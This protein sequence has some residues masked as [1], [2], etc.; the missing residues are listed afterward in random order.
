MTEWREWEHPRDNKGKFIRKGVHVNLSGGIIARVLGF[1]PDGRGGAWV[2]VRTPSGRTANVPSDRMTVAQPPAGQIYV[3]DGAL[4]SRFST[5]SDAS[6]PSRVGQVVEIAGDDSVSVRWGDGMIEHN[7]DP[8]SLTSDTARATTV[9]PNIRAPR[10]FDVPLAGDGL[11]VVTGEH[12]TVG[13]HNGVVTDVRPAVDA[14]G[15]DLVVY[16]DE[17]ERA[18]VTTADRVQHVMSTVQGT[19]D[20]TVKPTQ[21]IINPPEIETKTPLRSGMRYITDDDRTWLRDQGIVIPPAWQDVQVAE[22]RDASLL[23]VGR[24]AKG[25]AQYVYSAQY[26][27]NQA[28][29]KFARVRALASSLNELDSRLSDDARSDDS[30]AALML[31]RRMG[32]RPGSD[33]DTGA[34]KEARGATNLK[35]GDVHVDG[36]A[37]ALRFTGKKG[38]NI[39]L[40]VN[41]PEVAALLRDRV[42][43]RD[44]GNRL[45]NTNE[46]KTASYFKTYAPNFKLKDLRTLVAN[47]TALGVIANEPVPTSAAELRTARNRVGDQVSRVLGNT[48]DVALTS[49]INPAV[50][51]L[52]ESK[53]T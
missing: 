36:D 50:F 12:V 46:R 1:R 26:T 4:V 51:A 19:D 34:E 38:V 24:D 39:D 30:A 14:N 43:D 27:A 2:S 5:V 44:P 7:V 29:A 20:V 25:R 21:W 49:Y 42:A 53:I 40:P 16:D 48:R 33:A 6:H 9:T 45:F 28:A 11:P 35:V 23:A 13:D 18:R 41:D 52:W 32:L 22:N 31:I 10:M 37:V 15:H 8:S 47:E 3:G 17:A